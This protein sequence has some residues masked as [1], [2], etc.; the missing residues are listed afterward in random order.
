[1]IVNGFLTFISRTPSSHNRMNEFQVARFGDVTFKP[2]FLEQSDCTLDS[3]HVKSVDVRI[4]GK[5]EADVLDIEPG[6]DFLHVQRYGFFEF[7]AADEYRIDKVVVDGTF[8]TPTTIN[9]R[10][11]VHAL[12]KNINI[13]RYGHMLLDSHNTSKDASEWLSESVINAH[14]VE[15]YGSLKPGLLSTIL[16]EEG[17]YQENDNDSLELNY[18][19]TEIIKCK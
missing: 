10:G 2:Q 9:L 17:L 5:L 14:E 6:W 7:I 11:K 16:L 12:V 3:F 8:T 18:G 1:M 15:V 19:N 4:D 13:G